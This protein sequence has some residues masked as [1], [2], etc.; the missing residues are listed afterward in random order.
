MMKIQKII[1]L[2]LIGI[3]TITQSC[4]SL[5]GKNNSS[6]SDYNNVFFYQNG[7]ETL[8]SK[9]DSINIEKN[10]FSLRF[11]NK[12]YNSETKEFY[13]IQIAAFLDIQELDKI[14]I[15]MAKQDL[16]CFEPGSGMAPSMSGKYENIF[17]NNSGHHYLM[18]EDTSSKRLN[19]LK[20]E[21][22]YYKFEFEI[23]GIRKD[24]K[25]V[26]MKETEFSKFYLA[27][28]IDRNLNGIIDENEL[29][30]LIINIK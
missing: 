22:E 3:L 29:T 12:K 4:K 19:L 17:I 20:S 24:K 25:D 9:V 16:N 13:S 26:S 7:K 21:G 2:I 23:N 18:Y 6:N 11:Y 14:K 8:L 15:G 1:L 5:K 27:I 30:K 10:N 28:L